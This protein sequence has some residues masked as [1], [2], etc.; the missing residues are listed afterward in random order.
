MG[1]AKIIR[2]DSPKNILWQLFRIEVEKQNL[3]EELLYQTQRY[4]RDLRLG[5]EKKDEK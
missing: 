5:K 2:Q 4:V 3:P 1:D